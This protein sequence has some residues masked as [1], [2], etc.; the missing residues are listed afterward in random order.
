MLKTYKNKEK[1]KGG[2]YWNITQWKVEVVEGKEGSLP[3]GTMQKY[4]KIP[5]LV[6]IPLAL[7]MGAIFVVFLPF[8]GLV[9][10]PIVLVQKS[11]ANK[12]LLNFVQKFIELTTIRVV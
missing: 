11:L 10:L 12:N 8:V 1:V 6:F 4:I 5:A 3:G 7:I 2:F 9:M